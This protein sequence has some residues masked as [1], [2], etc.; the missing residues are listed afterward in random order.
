MTSVER[1]SFVGVKVVVGYILV[2]FPVTR[3]LLTHNISN[4]TR[5][6]PSLFLSSNNYLDERIETQLFDSSTTLKYQ[7][8][9]RSNRGAT[10][11]WLLE[12]DLSRHWT[13][14]GWRSL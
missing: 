13:E 1:G 12:R 8:L 3:C 2:L 10:D 4:A 7:G 14:L 11:N 5:R 6:V 9:T